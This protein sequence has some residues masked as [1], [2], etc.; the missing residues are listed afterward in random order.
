MEARNILK[1]HSLRATSHRCKVLD[2][3]IQSNRAL[4]H[5]DLEGNF[6]NKINR[7]SLYRMLYSFS[8]KNIVNEIID[9]NRVTNY[10]FNKQLKK[11]VQHSYFKCK[12]CNKVIKLPALPIEYVKCFEHIHIEKLNVL[13]EGT[14]KTC[15]TKIT[16][17]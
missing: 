10:I 7:V 14:C 12:T 4:T 11:H 5:L 1:Q 3:M 2:Y 9:S 6:K 15:C 8:E 16:D 13:A 17:N